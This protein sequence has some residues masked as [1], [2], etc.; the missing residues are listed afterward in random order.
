M[1]KRVRVELANLLGRGLDPLLGLDLLLLCGRRLGLLVLGCPGDV[2]RGREVL[3]R[4]GSR[5]HGHDVGRDGG[6]DPVAEL[7]RGVVEHDVG[8]ADVHGLVVALHGVLVVFAADVV[9]AGAFENLELEIQS[10]LGVLGGLPLGGRV[11]GHAGFLPAHVRAD[12]DELLGDDDLGDVGDTIACGKG[13]GGSWV[14]KG[15]YGKKRKDG[16]D[17]FSGRG[18]AVG[19]GV[20]ASRGSYLRR[21]GR[22]ARG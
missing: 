1:G 22:P 17:R 12:A 8:V 19:A 5:L 18:S 4:R 9:E 13:F 21:S 15:P 20:H 14:R 3:E 11:L 10:G 7:L 16:G 2:N 6:G